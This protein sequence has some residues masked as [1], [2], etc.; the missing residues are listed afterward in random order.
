MKAFRNYHHNFNILSRAA[1][2][3]YLQHSEYLLKSFPNAFMNR[4][5]SKCK[6]S[7][8][9]DTDYFSFILKNSVWFEYYR[10]LLN[11]CSY[12][13]T[14]NHKFTHYYLLTRSCL[15][16]LTVFIITSFYLISTRCHTK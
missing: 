2:V 12:S 1:I 11:V 7:I 5:S 6:S 13:F 16:C 4:I 10:N 9:N 15:N 3:F 8:S 14:I